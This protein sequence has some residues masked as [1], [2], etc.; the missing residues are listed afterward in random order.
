MD[1]IAIVTDTNS[2][3]F[4]HEA[5]NIGLFVLPMPFVID[6]EPKLDGIDLTRDEFYAHLKGKSSITTSQPSVGEVSDFWKNILKDYDKIVHIPTSSCLSASCATAQ[7]LAKEEEFAGKVFV[8]DNGR[9]S[10]SLKR[11]AYD[12]VALRDKGWDAQAI[13]DEITAR[14]DEHSIYFSLE[15]MEYL[16]RGGRISPAVAAIGSMLKLRP[17]LRVF[18]GKLEKFTMPRTIP[19][20]KEA[21]KM[22]VQ[23][24]LTEK[25]K[26][27]PHDELCIYLAHGENTQETDSWKA[28]I[29]KQFPT[30]PF[31]SDDPMSLS[32]SCHTG[33]GTFAIGICRIVK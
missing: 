15:S 10:I 13:A 9:I 31:A 1:K 4:P 16:K 18:Q 11:S 24:D 22:A 30:I 32:V 7:N 8:V 29:E 5:D 23:K 21:M 3:M 26:D 25:F 17:V 27:V 12:A 28:E 19:K 33:P 6:G 2:G 20:A 14:K